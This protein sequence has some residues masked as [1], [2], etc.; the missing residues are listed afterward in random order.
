MKPSTA[1]ALD[2]IAA[3]FLALFLEL[4][5]IRWLP[6]NILSLAYFSNLVLLAS[7]FGLGL[8][9]LSLN[10]SRDTFRWFPLALLAA[11]II[12]RCLRWFEVIVSPEQGELIWSYFRGNKTGAFPFHI[13]VLTAL[14]ATY[15]ICAALFTLLGRKIGSLMNGLRP[16]K[17]YALDLT[18]SLLGIIIFTLLSFASSA[19]SRPATWLGLVGLIAY[20][21]LRQEKKFALIALLC[22]VAVTGTVYF[23]SI[24]ETWSPYYGMQTNKLEDGSVQLFVNRFFHQQAVNFDADQIIK[25]KYSLPYALKKNPDKVLILGAGMGND[26]AI[27]LANNA[28]EI[29]AVEIDPVIADLGRQL[30]PNHPYADPRVRLAV[31]DARSW[32]KKDQN[33]YDMIVLGTLDSHTLLSAMST[34]RL[35]NFIYTLE[36]MRDVKNHLKPDGIAVFMFS[37]PP[38]HWLGIKLINSVAFVFNQ[39]PPLVYL[40]TKAFLFNLMAVAG[41]GLNQ[42][43]ADQTISKNPFLQVYG[44][45]TDVGDFQTDDWPYL[46]LKNHTI[47]SHYLKAIGLFTVLSFFSIFFFMPRKKLGRQDLNFFALGAAFMLLETKSVTSLSLLFGST[48]LVN[49]FVFGG[50]MVLLLAANLLAA[51]LKLKRLGAVYLLLG[52]TLLLNYWLP[53]SLWL[54]QNFWLKA[55]LPSL[56]T[57]LPIFFGAIIFSHHFKG[58]VSPAAYYGI[59]LAGAVLGGFLEYSSMLFGLNKLYLLAGALYLI[60]Y[61]ASSRQSSVKPPTLILPGE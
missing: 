61:L 45:V 56:L 58:V 23:S 39:P 18:G 8:G 24:Y 42:I 43:I 12:F 41:P 57:A 52:A 34:V 38:S 30:H 27:A 28:K 60:S 10:K 3:S 46:Y 51:K 14:G 2:L 54:G 47:P 25:D 13:G 59:N 36:A 22:A 16:I 29:Q 1:Q 49:A 37:P 7:F 48:W 4:I 40:S 31:D 11:V 20:W 32:L 9:A 33:K 26:A 19:I 15:I 6:A 53:T 44:Q 35:D 50:I 55:I 5:F 17:A 21:L